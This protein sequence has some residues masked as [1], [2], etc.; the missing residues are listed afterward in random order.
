MT[1]TPTSTPSM[2]GKTCVVTGANSGIGK[3]LALSLAKRGATVVMVCR[4]RERGEAALADVRRESGRS[5]GIT[6]MLCDVGSLDSVRQFAA[7]WNTTR[8]NVDIDVLFNNAGV[9]LPARLNSPEGFESTFAI[10]HLGPHAITN[11]LI[12]RLRG[13]RVI[14]T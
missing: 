6:L 1:E 3:S 10:N 2:E 4:S 9:Y 5:E 11:L 13:A 8:G 7:D 14:T 12:D